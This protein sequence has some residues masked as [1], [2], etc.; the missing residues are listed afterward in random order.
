[1]QMKQQGGE[2]DWKEWTDNE[3]KRMFEASEA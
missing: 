3:R 2:N 1:M